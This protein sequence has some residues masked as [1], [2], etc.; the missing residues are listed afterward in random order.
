MLK[1]LRVCVSVATLGILA[2]IAP[3]SAQFPP[4]PDDA[5]DPAQPGGS[6]AKRAAAPQA[7]GPSINGSW[8]GQ[9]KQVGS[10]APYGLE[11]TINANGA[12]TK[13][14]D[15]DCTGKLTRVGSSKSYA[16][17][18]E[19][20]TKGQVDKGGRCPD[21]TITMARQ[22]DELAVGWFAS[23]QG[24]TIVAYGMLRKK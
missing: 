3:A 8:S 9:L 18:V 20:I 17:F 4:G 1:P 5:T 21:G 12:Q 14:P 2:V 6:K 10:E 7:A 22:G 11:L 19:V 16:F 13:Y 23:V 15:L 24:N